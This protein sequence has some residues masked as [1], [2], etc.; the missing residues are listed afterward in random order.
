MQGGGKPRRGIPLP[1]LAGNNTGWRERAVD[2]DGRAHGRLARGGLAEEDVGKGRAG[3]RGTEKSG[4]RAG[5]KAMK[6]AEEQGG[7]GEREGM[8]G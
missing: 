7:E 3:E 1:G 2:V 5:G 8:T 6:K 4:G